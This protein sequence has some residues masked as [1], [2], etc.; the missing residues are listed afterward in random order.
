LRLGRIVLAL[1]LW[2]ALVAAAG[3]TAYRRL[4]DFDAAQWASWRDLRQ[5]FMAGASVPFDFVA[6]TLGLCL[7][8]ILG[9]GFLAWRLVRS[10]ETGRRARVR[11]LPPL[12]AGADPR[13]RSEVAGDGDIEAFARAMAVFEVWSEPA[14]AWMTDTL[15]EE[16]A[17]LSPA[18]WAAMA[19]WGEAAARLRRHAE[20]RGLVPPGV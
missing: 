16:L 5:G 18:G 8:A 9:I 20:S 15:A 11:P 1:G 13:P 4:Y 17:R 10:A 6:L 7:A 3:M 19:D 14:P 2:P 12:P